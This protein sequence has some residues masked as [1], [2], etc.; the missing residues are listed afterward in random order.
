MTYTRPTDHA[1]RRLY[2]GV[3]L[4][5]QLHGT[6]VKVPAPVENARTTIEHLEARRKTN[7]TARGHRQ[8]TIDALLADPD[9]DIT[10]TVVLEDHAATTANALLEAVDTAR[11]NLAGVI[12]QHSDE[13]VIAIRKTMFT[14]AAKVLEAAAKLSPTDTAETLLR[15]GR[16]D[17]ARALVDVPTAHMTVISA[18]RLRAS[19]Y[20][21]SDIGELACT[22]WR[23]PQDIRQD[24][25]ANID[26]ALRMINGIRQGGELWLG[27]Y[28]EVDDASRKAT[29][30][31]EA[32]RQAEATAAQVAIR[33][34]AAK[35][36][37]NLK[38]A[39]DAK[40]RSRKPAPSE[41][42]D[43]A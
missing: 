3:R 29:A 33:A 5:E 34:A 31:I 36:R 39:A 4:L 38:T 41:P 18:Y 15:A 43:A 32:A 26:G 17:E 37:E 21:R 8:A 22:R 23:N 9:A 16:N 1:G 40:A 14:P 24:P 30:A 12:A 20:S 25:V 6:G 35:R 10:A 11:K 28:T 19:V 13:L 27:T 42:L 7:A 2:S